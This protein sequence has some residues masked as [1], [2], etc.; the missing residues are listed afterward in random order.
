MSLIHRGDVDRQNDPLIQCLEEITHYFHCDVSIETLLAGLPFS[1]R[2]LLPSDF[3][4]AMNRAGL[5]SSL[6]EQSLESLSGS[7]L[8]AVLLMLN[9]TAVV[10][11]RVDTK[12]H[13]AVV[14]TPGK[15]RKEIELQQ[16]EGV[17][18]GYLITVDA[19]P[20][21]HQESSKEGSTRTYSWFREAIIPYWGTYRDVLLASLMVN[22]FALVSPLFV[23]NVY[24]RVVPNQAYETLW[25][26]V[27]GVLIAFSFDFAIKLI[28]AN[29]IDQ[30]G[31]QIDIRLSSHLLERILGLKLAARPGATGS[32]MNNLAEFDSIRQFL[33]SATILT[34]IDL[35]FVLLFLALI[36]WIAP[37]LVVIPLVCMLLAAGIAFF[38]NS[39]LQKAIE[40]S[41]QASCQRQSFLL[42]T[43][44][45]LET[46]KASSAESQHQYHW[47]RFNRKLAE[48]NL[49]VR[50]LQLYSSQTATFILQAGTILIIST[51]VYLIGSG[52]LSMGGLIAVM[53]ISGRCT[54]PVIQSIGLLNQFQRTRQALDYTDS[55]MKLPQ[56]RTR[57]RHFLVPETC[58][59]KIRF[60]HICFSYPDSP[61]LLKD[62]SLDIQPGERVAILG[63]MG[64]GKSTLLQLIMGLW[65]SS[66]GC[67]SLDD[68]DIRQIDPAFLRNQIGYVPQTV[69]LFSGSIRDN[70]LM[71]R[72]GI[73]DEALILAVQQA[74]LGSL[75]SAHPQGLDF[76]VGEAG[77]N[78]SG[79]QIQSIGIAR[80]LL[81]DPTVLVL[82]EPSSAMDNQSEAQLIKTLSGLK[83][84]TILIVTHKK[85]LVTGADK[86][87]VLDQG[88]VAGIKDSMESSPVKEVKMDSRDREFA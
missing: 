12:T 35:P 29:A 44:L 63:R 32:F 66:D 60:D 81:G 1:E 11:Y 79:G 68:V 23:M 82:D 36:A 85:S 73:S 84:K 30:A 6:S 57:D 9:D 43:L 55:L 2:N 24:D 33:T 26:L 88:R 7:D 17:Y 72:Q 53:M 58:L 20:D 31:K 76:L 40:T 16:L 5:D 77:R 52:S 71:G 25:M 65:E 4:K 69:T 83:D 56:E 78:L 37:V 45:G 51:G 59:G 64:S 18:S 50:K 10:V 27:A 41:Q 15:E 49:K 8:P 54:A 47:E 38:I 22:L 28:R 87:I 42:E 62:I 67:I 39:P 74:G 86:V 80:A 48:L 46:I 19:Q 14:S 75:L 61:P 70:L 34:L 21:S 3:Q 13:K